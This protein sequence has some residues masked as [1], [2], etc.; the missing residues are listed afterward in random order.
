[1]Q[2]SNTQQAHKMAL[3]AQHEKVKETHSP[4]QIAHQHQ[5]HCHGQCLRRD[6]L[7]GTEQADPA[8]FFTD[9]PDQTTQQQK[10]QPEFPRFQHGMYQLNKGGILLSPL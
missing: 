7:P 3:T 5:S 6:P 1:M 10:A 8:V 9:Q 2:Y 4:Q